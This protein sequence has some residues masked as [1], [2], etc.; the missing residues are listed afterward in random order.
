MQKIIKAF[1][2]EFL[3]R[4]ASLVEE[5]APAELR[6][7][8]DVASILTAACLLEKAEYREEKKNHIKDE[9]MDAEDKYGLYIET[10]DPAVLDMARDELR[11]AA[12]YMAHAQAVQDPHALQ[13]MARYQE[14]YERLAQRIG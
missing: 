1:K 9:L 10:K 3:Q 8:A 12:Y 13:H 6:I 7:A 2:D 14:W 4:A 11:H 5:A